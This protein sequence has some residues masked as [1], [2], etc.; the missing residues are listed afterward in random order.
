LFFCG[1]DVGKVIRM[2]NV[3]AVIRELLEREAG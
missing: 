3:R 1:A 2:S